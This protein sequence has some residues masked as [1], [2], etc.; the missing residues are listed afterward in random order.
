MISALWITSSLITGL[1]LLSAVVGR[2]RVLAV[3]CGAVLAQGW[4]LHDLT[5]R[6]YYFAWLRSEPILIALRV[7]VAID[8]YGRVVAPY[9]DMGAWR[10]GVPAVSVALAAALLQIGSTSLGKALARSYALSRFSWS[11]LALGLVG[12]WAVAVVPAPRPRVVIAHYWALVAYCFAQA[13]PSALIYALGDAWVGSLTVVLMT[14]VIVTQAAWAFE[15]A[16][17]PC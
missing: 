14:G 11:V 12:A 17:N 16:R 7:A 5:G 10:V 15:L 2:F 1:L 6:A 4:L 3:Y 8:A 9:R 13:I